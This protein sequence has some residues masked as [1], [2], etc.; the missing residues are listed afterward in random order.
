MQ[1]L[2]QRYA[3]RVLS[4]K[5][6]PA[7]AKLWPEEPQHVWQR[8]SAGIKGHVAGDAFRS[9]P[10]RGSVVSETDLHDRADCAGLPL[11][12]PMQLA[13]GSYAHL[14]QPDRDGSPRPFSSHR[15]RFVTPGR[16]TLTQISNSSLPPNLSRDRN[17]LASEGDRGRASDDVFCSV[18][19]ARGLSSRATRF[20]SMSP[21]QLSLRRVRPGAGQANQE[22]QPGRYPPLFQCDCFPR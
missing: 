12:S 6:N 16:A 18:N 8:R 21:A 7:Q 15:V 11:H 22:L 10:L 19:S 1:V 4:K 9:F 17:A 3:R 5:N 13:L 20:G 2:K 14:S